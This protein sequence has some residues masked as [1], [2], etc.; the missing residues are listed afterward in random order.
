MTAEGY[1]NHV[2]RKRKEAKETKEAGLWIHK[3]NRQNKGLLGNSQ[4][5]HAQVVR[6]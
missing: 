1:L 4:N 3:V 6:A 5:S 2:E